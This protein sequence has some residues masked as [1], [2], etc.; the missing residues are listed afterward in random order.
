MTYQ[1]SLGDPNHVR[2]QMV[3]AAIAIHKQELFVC[4]RLPTKSCKKSAMMIRKTHVLPYK[5]AIMEPKQRILSK[6]VTH[7]RLLFFLACGDVA[8]CLAY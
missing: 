6:A 3:A 1:K 8:K 7:K 5:V 4:A 2:G